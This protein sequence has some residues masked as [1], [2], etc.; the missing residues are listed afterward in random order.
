MVGTSSFS[1]CK[2]L[3]EEPEHRRSGWCGAGDAPYGRGSQTKKRISFDLRSIVIALVTLAGCGP[4]VLRLYP[5]HAKRNAVAVIEIKT[6][7][8]RVVAFDDH[9]LP[10]P[11]RDTDRIAVE[12]L[13]GGHCA[14]FV[15]PQ[16]WSA[17][18][19]PATGG[20]QRSNE[21]AE[22]FWFEAKAG[23]K[24]VLQDSVKVAQMLDIHT[25]VI[26]EVR[27][28]GSSKVIG[29]TMVPPSREASCH[30]FQPQ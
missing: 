19:R 14:Q 17:F 1:T 4:S 28:D 13:P 23:A 8:G 26:S 21:E 10:R 5:G 11:V 7:T 2:Q 18:D 20:A 3:L 16:M 25:M 15:R 27:P 30:P 29:G 9:A 24:Y 12:I 22:A 6:R